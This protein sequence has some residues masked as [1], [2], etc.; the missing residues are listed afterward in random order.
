MSE[1]FHY[2]Y[3][4]SS[5]GSPD[6]RYVGLTDDLIERLARHNRGGVTHTCKFAP[7]QIETAIAFR[8]RMKAAA[9][10]KYLK[11]GSGREFSRRHF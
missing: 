6:R 4:L 8:D 5:I 10:E 3:V 2:V 1:K 9:F 7:W 11:S